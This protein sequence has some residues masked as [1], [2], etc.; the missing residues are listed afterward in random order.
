M[1]NEGKFRCFPGLDKNSKGFRSLPTA[2]HAELELFSY[3]IMIHCVLHYRHSSLEIHSVFNL[4][5]NFCTF[6]TVTGFFISALI[7]RRENY[8]YFAFLFCLGPYLHY[9]HNN[10][11]RRDNKNDV[12]ISQFCSSKVCE[13]LLLLSLSVKSARFYNFRSLNYD[14]AKSADKCI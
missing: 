11:S 8:H 4:I 13:Y 6:L 1:Q 7:I 14:I 9:Y 2:V 3:P 12:H 10:S 5:T